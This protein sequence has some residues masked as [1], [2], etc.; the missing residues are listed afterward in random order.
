MVDEML[1]LRAMYIQ[2]KALKGTM[3]LILLSLM[4]WTCQTAIFKRKLYLF[5][6]MARSLMLQKM[7]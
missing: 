5:H 4:L 3:S 1:H 6:L 2:S 7:K